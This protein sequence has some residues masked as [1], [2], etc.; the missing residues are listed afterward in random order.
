MLQEAG[1][2]AYPPLANNK[3][4]ESPQLAVRDFWVEQEHMEVGVRRHAGIPWHLSETPLSVKRAAPVMGQDNDYVF[5][6]LL[7]MGSDEI[8]GLVEREVIK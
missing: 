3:V 4:L 2:A 5:G 7:G 8:A 1:V 6:E